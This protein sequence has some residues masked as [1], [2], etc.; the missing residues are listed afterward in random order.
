MASKSYLILGT[1]LLLSAMV[2]QYKSDTQLAN[3]H[4]SWMLKYNKQYYSVLEQEYRRQVFEQ[5]VKFIEETNQK[6]NDFVLE[7]NEYADLT[8]EEFSIQYLHYDHQFSDEQTTKQQIK[9]NNLNQEINWSKYAGSVKNQGQC[10]SYI[11]QT[12]DLLD[13]NNKIINNNYNQL[14]QQDLIDCSSSYGNKGCQGGFVSNTLNYVKDKGLA[15]EKDYPTTSTSGICKNVQRSFHISNYIT[16]S[17]CEDLIKALTNSTV[18][19]A[20][21]ASSWQFY[22]SGILT[23]CGTSLNHGA[24]L[25]G[26][27]NDGVWTLKNT[28]GSSW[29]EQGFIR[30]GAGNTCGVCKNGLQQVF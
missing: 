25:I 24:L 12:L 28:W 16:I 23:Q 15:Y 13:A 29:G 22:K 4:S 19:V 17:N 2:L 20:V 8:S 9:E 7:I 18:T 3:N 14:S 5:N 11:F 10:A 1:V 6:Q 21:D 27:T 30:L 26:I